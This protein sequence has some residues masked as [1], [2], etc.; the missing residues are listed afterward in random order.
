MAIDYKSSGVDIA[1]GESLVDWLKGSDPTPE[2]LKKQ[3]VSGIGGF[4]ALFSVNFSQMKSPC[5]VSATDGVGTKI[6]LASDFNRY[7]EVG[8]DLVAMCVN[9]MICCGAKPLFFLDYY[10]TGRLQLEP[11]KEFLTGVRNACIESQCVLIGGETAE[12]PGIYQ[13]NDFDAAGFSVGVVDQEKALGS[14]LVCEGD[15]ILGVSSSGF[16]SN[17]FSLV[18]K[19]FKSDIADWIDQL[20]KPTHLYPQLV[21]QILSKTKAHAFAHITG[22]GIDNVARV[23]PKG[24]QAKVLPWEV[25]SLFIEA[26]NRSKLSWESL[27]KT[28]NCGLGLVVVLPKESVTVVKAEAQELGFDCFDLGSIVTGDEPLLVD[29]NGFTEQG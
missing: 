9:D 17:G 13:G 22:G 27:L 23:I 15:Q 2:S 11:A 1:K 26:K 3:V 24:L 20:I 10:S 18:R 16:H 21:S 8:Q 29:Y 12:M 4:S 5:L 19:L 14:H 25:P 28:F 7:A 6:K